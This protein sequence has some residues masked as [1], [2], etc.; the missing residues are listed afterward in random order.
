MEPYGHP[1]A[2][3]ERLFQKP[4]YTLIYVSFLLK[5]VPAAF[6]R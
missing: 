2:W 6:T 1:Q 3:R 4:D 5:W